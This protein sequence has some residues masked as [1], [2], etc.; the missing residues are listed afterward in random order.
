MGSA[1]T[2]AATS[3]AAGGG[4]VTGASGKGGG[5]FSS[6]AGVAGGVGSGIAAWVGG[7]AVVCKVTLMTSS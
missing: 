5:D 6:E 3:L 7:L 2:G 4:L 1:T